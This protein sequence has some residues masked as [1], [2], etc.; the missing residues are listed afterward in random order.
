MSWDVFGNTLG[1]FSEG[2][3]KVSEKHEE[4]V[5]KYRFSEKSGSN[6]PESGV[7]RLTF[8]AKYLVLGTKYLVLGTKYLVPNTKYSVPR[9][10]S[11][12]KQSKIHGPIFFQWA[13]CETYRKI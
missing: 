6:F 3:G 9:T 8:L 1:T 11:Y 4:C 7:R 12:I 5:E 10:K 13:P 2:F